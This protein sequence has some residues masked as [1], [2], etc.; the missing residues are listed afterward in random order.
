MAPDTS[1][2]LEAL[3]LAKVRLMP[4][5]KRRRIR[6]AAGVSREALARDLRCTSAAVEAWE[7]G[8]R[9]PT[10]FLGAQY[11]RLLAQLDELTAQAKAAQ[12]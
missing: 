10:G 12:P 2:E 3:A 11:G 7:A 5:A 6:T 9:Q 4:P 8:R 1:L